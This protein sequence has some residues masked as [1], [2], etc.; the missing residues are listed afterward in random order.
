MTMNFQSK[1]DVYPITE[2][3]DWTIAEQM[4]KF[5]NKKLRFAWN[6]NLIVREKMSHQ[7][8]DEQ[9]KQPNQQK[10]MMKWTIKKNQEE[11]P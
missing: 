3:C 10:T 11:I 6:E 4:K 9:V 1:S 7:G 2:M 8:N 5:V